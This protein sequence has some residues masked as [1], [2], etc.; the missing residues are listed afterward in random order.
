[1]PINIEI[2]KRLLAF[3]EKNIAEMS[4]PNLSKN[5]LLKEEDLRLAMERRLQT[6][7]EACIDIASHIISSESLGIVEHNKDALILLGEKGIISKELSKKL[8]IATDMR[9]VLVHGY[10]HIDFNLFYRAI[11]EDIVDLKQFIQEI[12]AFLEKKT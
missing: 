1:M 4:R 5:D 7:I 11:T 12:Q 10:G 8:S 3:L 9:N 6:S 2:I